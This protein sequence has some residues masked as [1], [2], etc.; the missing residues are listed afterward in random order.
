VV[1]VDGLLLLHLMNED[2]G[3]LGITSPLTVRRIDV[4]M[5]EY[6]LR[7]ERKQVRRHAAPCALEENS[8]AD[9]LLRSKEEV[10]HD[11]GGIN[12][13]FTVLHVF[14]RFPTRA[15]IFK[16][17]AIGI[18][19][20]ISP[21]SVRGAQQ[22]GDVDE[23]NEGSDISGSDTPSELFDDDDMYDDDDVRKSQ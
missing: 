7:F 3:H 17:T 4:A 12:M 11:C 9:F 8:G 5:Q 6:R 23:E 22:A 18:F 15:C 19:P 1:Q 20:F 2:W 10:S 14:R 21:L 16:R 13:C